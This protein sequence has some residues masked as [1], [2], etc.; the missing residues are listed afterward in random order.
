MGVSFFLHALGPG[1]GCLPPPQSI[2]APPSE[3]DGWEYVRVPKRSCIEPR[4]TAPLEIIPSASGAPPL[5]ATSASAPAAIP[6]DALQPGRPNLATQVVGSEDDQEEFDPSSSTEDSIPN[7]PTPSLDVVYLQPPSPLEELRAYVSLVLRIAKVM[8]LQVEQPPVP[9][10]DRVY[11]DINQDQTSPVHLG[12]IPS[13]LK[14]LL[15]H[16]MVVKIKSNGADVI[17]LVPWWPHQV[18]FT[19]LCQIAAY[20]LRL[21]ARPDLLTKNGG[22]I[23]HPGIRSLSLTAWRITPSSSR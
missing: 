5:L 19:V 21:P 13:L 8:D 14:L 23:H 2:L 1:S 11:E 17:L 9:N 18:R 10:S 6:T 12:F 3:D 22:T 4:S 16:K 15:L 20:F 7:L